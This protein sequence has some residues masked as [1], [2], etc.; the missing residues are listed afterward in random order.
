ML[1][2]D[3]PGYADYAGPRPVPAGTR[4]LVTLHPIYENLNM[5][6]FGQGEDGHDTKQESIA[7][8]T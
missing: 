6:S 7:A 4:R 8:A 1:Q 5:M 2:R 3:L